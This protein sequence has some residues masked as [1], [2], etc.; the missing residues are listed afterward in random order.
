MD[1]RW[2][3]LLV[4]DRYSFSSSFAIFFFRSHQKAGH[5]PSH[6]VALS[7]PQRQGS[8]FPRLR[9][10]S[11]Q[12]WDELRMAL[13]SARSQDRSSF[14]LVQP[15]GFGCRVQRYRVPHDR[16]NLDVL[17]CGLGVD[18]RDDPVSRSPGTEKR[19][20]SGRFRAGRRPVRKSWS[21]DRYTGTS[22]QLSR[23]EVRWAFRGS[24]GPIQNQARNCA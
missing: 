16:R 7:T 4:F 8:A 1:R 18:E 5:N 20:W 9:L 12:R 10:K 13:H 23:N 14:C 11:T 21:G 17:P 15:N 2:E 22:K 24:G 19:I 6:A 3:P